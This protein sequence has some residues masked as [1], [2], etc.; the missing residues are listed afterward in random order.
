MSLQDE[1][2]KWASETFPNSTVKAK[3]LHLFEELDEAYQEAYHDLL[4]E[5]IADAGLITLHLASSLGVEI[6][7]ISIN[8]EGEMW[9][10]FERCKKRKWKPADE[11][12]VVRHA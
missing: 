9:H 12:G 7:N 5:E 2:T 1:V 10:K 6:P 4:R 3:I 11:N 8:F